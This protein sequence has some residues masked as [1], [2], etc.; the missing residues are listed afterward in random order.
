MTQGNFVLTAPRYSATPSPGY[1]TE[2]GAQ[3]DFKFNLIKMIE[4]IVEEIN[5][6]H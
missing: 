1:H 5:K 2:T 4:A 6:S 3:D